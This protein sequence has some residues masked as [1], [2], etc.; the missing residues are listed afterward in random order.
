MS[1]GNLERPPESPVSALDTDI[2]RKFAAF[3]YLLKILSGP[4]LA[5]ALVIFGAFEWHTTGK[6]VRDLMV[7]TRNIL[8][9]TSKF[10]KEQSKLIEE[11][12]REL[13]HR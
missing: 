4:A 2:R 10:M 8:I 1:S 5:V 12:S 3:E 11:M 6:E 7:E 9:D 13:R